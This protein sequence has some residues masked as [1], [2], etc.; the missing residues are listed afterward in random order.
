[1][2]FGGVPATCKSES[3]PYGNH[4]PLSDFLQ[5]G[6]TNNKTG[7]I[8]MHVRFVYAGWLLCI[9]LLAI[10]SYQPLNFHSNEGDQY[11]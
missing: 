2:E 3:T 9:D 6:D 10:Y 1:M 4:R 11:V 7:C 5:P 8:V